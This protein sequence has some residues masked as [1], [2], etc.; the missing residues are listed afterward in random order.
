LNPIHK[1]SSLCSGRQKPG[2]EPPATSST[3]ACD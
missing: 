2:F 1:E 3:A